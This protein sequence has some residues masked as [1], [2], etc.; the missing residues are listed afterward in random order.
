MK[1]LFTSTTPPL[2][3]IAAMS[4]LSRSALRKQCNRDRVLLG[5]IA[6]VLCNRWALMPFLLLV[7]RY[8]ACG[9]L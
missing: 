3:R 7:M 5:V 9:A 2:L 8:T 4:Q 6:S 1:V